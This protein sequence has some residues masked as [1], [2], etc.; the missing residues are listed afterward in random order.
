MNR[1][2]IWLENIG[3]TG[4]DS[5]GYYLHAVTSFRP[6]GGDSPGYWFDL[7]GQW[8]PVLRDSTGNDCVSRHP[9]SV[10]PTWQFLSK[11]AMHEED[12]K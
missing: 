2:A 11:F 7:I 5:A 12:L 3:A 8:R 9:D 1:R 6:S 4:F 10:F